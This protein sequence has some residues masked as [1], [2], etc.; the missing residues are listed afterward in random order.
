[1]TFVAPI[2]KK[3][4]LQKDY[5]T[6]MCQES[7]VEY[8]RVNGIWRMIEPERQELFDRFIQEYETVRLAEGR[9]ASNPNFYKQLPFT[10]ADHPAAEMW[11]QRAHA[12]QVFVDSVI[13]D[14]EKGNNSPINI[15]DLGAGNG[16]LSN[17]MSRRGHCA[18]AVDLTINEFDGLGVHARYDHSFTP[19]QAEFDYL[20]IEDNQF[21]V[22]IFNAS[23][24]YSTDYA[25]TISEASRA[26]KPNGRI[27][28][29]DTP[30]YEQAESGHQMVAERESSFEKRFGFKSN[31]LNSQNFLI[32]DQIGWL[33]QQLG[34]QIEMIHT[35]PDFRRAVRRIKTKIKGE[36]ESA[37]FPILIFTKKESAE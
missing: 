4:L 2:T 29:I 19:I 8:Y 36:R 21:D 17:Q 11:K 18:T 6:L 28:I 30:V 32:V 26:T 31:S 22:V 27:V 7:G 13:K 16:W 3:P 1:M 34:G 9:K 20:P 25:Q 24:H 5:D 15:L 10:P 12:F 33:E 23:L 14:M 37:E 35:V